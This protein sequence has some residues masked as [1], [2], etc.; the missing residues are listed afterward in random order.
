M[1]MNNI[2]DSQIRREAQLQRF[3][4]YMLNQ[5]IN[6]AVEDLQRELPIML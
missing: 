1:A 4:T 2:L 3:A 6:P 5:Y